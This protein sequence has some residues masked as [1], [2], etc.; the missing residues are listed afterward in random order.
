MKY[1]QYSPE[2]WSALEQSVER[3]LQR[4][5][6]PVAAFDADGTLWDMDMG[7]GFFQHKIDRKL[8]PLPADPWDHYFGLKKK[9]GDPKEAYLWLAQILKSVSLDQARR[10]A[11]DAVDAIRPVPVF[12]DQKKLIELLRARG[13][14]VYIV[15]ASIK[16]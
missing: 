6:H 9:N 10:W 15:T 1:K 5:P 14:R 2:L 4:D 13:V 12:P 3:A 7:E 11:Q 16:W 8:I